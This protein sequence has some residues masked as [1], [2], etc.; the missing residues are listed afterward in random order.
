M[1]IYCEQ[2][3]PTSLSRWVEC[4]WFLE[5]D[6]AVMG[7]RVPPDGCLDILYDPRKGLRAI[8]AMTSEQRFNLAAGTCLVGIRFRP[9][10]AGPF[11][12]VSPAQLTNGSVSLE[13]LWSHRA[14]ELTRQMNDAK[15][16]RDAMRRLLDSLRAPASVPNP[17]QQ[18]IETIIKANGN[19]DVD[20]AA[21]HANLSARQF[22]R[23]CRIAHAAERPNWSAIAAEGEYFDQAHLI[24]DFREFIGATPVA[25]FSNTRASRGD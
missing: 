23:A 12:G 13:D 22:R 15:S 24:R 19:A 20:S 6:A 18:A 7:Y 5:S 14:R 2:P 8:G 16:I 1:P 21:R 9:G 11:L 3:P 4:G 17:V 10:M 25:V